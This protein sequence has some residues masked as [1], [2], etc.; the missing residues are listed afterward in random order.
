MAPLAAALPLLLGAMGYLDV[1]LGIATSMFSALALGVGVDFAVHFQHAYERESERGRSHEHALRKSMTTSGRAIRWN[2]TVLGL[3]F[4]VLCG[5]ELKPN[6]S[7]G[8][9]LSAAIATCYAMTL[10][11]LP[12]LLGLAR[13]RVGSGAGSP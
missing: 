12:A 8:L 10:L 6:H 1:R 13:R 9:L 11:L 5:S 3:G 7:L 4:L 2:A